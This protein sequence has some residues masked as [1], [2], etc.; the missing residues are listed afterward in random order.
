MDGEKQREVSQALRKG[1]RAPDF[2]LT[3]T[4]GN[5]SLADLLQ[6]GKVVLAFYTEDQTPICTAE[7][8]SFKD[9]YATLAELGAQVVAVSSDPLASHESFVKKLG[10]LPFALASDPSLAVAR[11]YGVADE[12]AKRARRAVFVIGQDGALLHANTFYN[13]GNPGQFMEVF[14]ALGLE[15]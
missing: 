11:A 4:A 12:G 10:G 13:P 14:Q 9:E 6:R 5:F 1:D 7:V 8:A 15:T 2:T 3:T